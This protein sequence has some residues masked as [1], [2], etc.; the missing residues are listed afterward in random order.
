MAKVTFE[1]DENEEKTDIE[2]IVNRY[3]MWNALNELSG[4][5]RSIYKGYYNEGDYCSVRE[6][7]VPMK[8]NPDHKIKKA[9]QVITDE[10]REKANM[11]GRWIEDSVTYLKADWVENEIN[12]ILD[13]VYQVL[14]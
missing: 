7:E 4:L 2:L 3:K 1:Y 14:D 9:V 8:H 12:R 10:E 5:R 11:E 13:D 6:A